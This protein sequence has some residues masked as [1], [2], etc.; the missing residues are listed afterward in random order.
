[1]AQSVR[2]RHGVNKQER[3]EA[4]IAPEQKRLIERA[5]QLRG[6]TVTDFVVLSA[7]REAAR[8]IKDFEVLSL[9]QEAR[10]VFVAAVLNPPSP[11]EALRAAARR[12]R[13][14]MGS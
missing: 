3:L 2:V 11:N 13:K 6:T 1:M 7:Q 9:A 12:Y 4:R 14:R 10:E 8:T 5:A